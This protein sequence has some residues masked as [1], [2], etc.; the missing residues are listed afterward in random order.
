MRP[1]LHQFGASTF[2]PVSNV[3]YRRELSVKQPV[4]L[5]WKKWT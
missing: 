1:G 5:A 4:Y 3:V 2:H